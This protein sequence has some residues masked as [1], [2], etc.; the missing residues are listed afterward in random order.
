MFCVV[1][2]KARGLKRNVPEIV[3]SRVYVEICLVRIYRF[4]EHVINDVKIK[5]IVQFSLNND[6]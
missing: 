6:N 4:A 1:Y 2:K 3:W 5:R